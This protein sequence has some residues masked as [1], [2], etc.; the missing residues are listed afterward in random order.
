MFYKKEATCAYSQRDRS[1]CSI[2]HFKVPE[3][4]DKLK[5]IYYS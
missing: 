1:L 4:N 3:V 2:L 5:G